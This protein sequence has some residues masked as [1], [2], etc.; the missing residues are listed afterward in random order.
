MPKFSLSKES[1]EKLEYVHDD[2]CLVVKRAIELTDTD[3]TV[4]EGLRTVT[5]QK[6]LVKAGASHTMNSRHLTGH[7]VD[8]VPMLGNH[9]RW[10]WPLCYR[11]A[12]AVKLSAQEYAIPVVWGGVWDRLLNGLEKS[13]EEEVNDYIVRQKSRS[14]RVFIDGPH[15]QIPRESYP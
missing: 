1:L 2:L 14:E 7:A 6:E 5:R 15:F 11:V 4:M 8:L 10:D 13:C 3:F 9:P 12:E